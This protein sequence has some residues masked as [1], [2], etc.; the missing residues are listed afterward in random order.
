MLDRQKCRDLRVSSLIVR[1]VLTTK[2]VYK[3][4]IDWKAIDYILLIG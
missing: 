2:N 1:A 3:H 4:G